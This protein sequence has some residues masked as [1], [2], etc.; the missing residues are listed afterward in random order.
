MPAPPAVKH[1]LSIIP[2]ADEDSRSR[3]GDI[4]AWRKKGKI[5]I[6]PMKTVSNFKSKEERSSVLTKSNKAVI[7]HTNSMNGA[8]K[9]KD[10]ASLDHQVVKKPFLRRGQGLAR[11]NLQPEDVKHPY[12]KGS[13]KIS[14]SVS[15]DSKKSSSILASNRL[16]NKSNTQLFQRVQPHSS[17]GSN[18]IGLTA[19][20]QRLELTVPSKN[21]QSVELGTWSQVLGADT[22]LSPPPNS[23]SYF[24]EWGN[25][26]KQDTLRL[27]T[28]QN[29]YQNNCPTMRNIQSPKR[30]L[31]SGNKLH[32]SPEVSSAV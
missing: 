31:N 11:Y 21:I 12:R 28:F 32:C 7:S 8:V 2:E 26:S 17:K 14:S 23:E 18:A 30:K 15:S 20:M 10:D 9:Q 3:D 29:N 6:E 13:V 5:Q 1:D 24:G 25:R 19:P 27:P 16:V 4:D 22:K